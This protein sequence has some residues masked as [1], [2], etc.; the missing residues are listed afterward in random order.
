MYELRFVKTENSK[1]MSAK[2][3][4]VVAAETPQSKF[5]NWQ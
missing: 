1:G 5:L 3:R 2:L 4:K